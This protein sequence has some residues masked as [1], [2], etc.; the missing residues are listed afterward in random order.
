MDA[1]VLI[2]QETQLLN[3]WAAGRDGFIP[4]GVV[5]AERY[6]TSEIRLL[7]LLK[8]VNGGSDWDLRDFLRSGGRK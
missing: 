5:N 1:A 2:T 7:Y 4:D 3:E 6:L 8:E